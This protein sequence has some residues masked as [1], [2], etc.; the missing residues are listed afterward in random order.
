MA[1]E[2]KKPEQDPVEGAPDIIDHELAEK[3]REPTDK[4][5]AKEQAREDRPPRGGS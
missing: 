2:R 5:G 1:N 3:S 4:D